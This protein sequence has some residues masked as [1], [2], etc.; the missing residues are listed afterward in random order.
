MGFDF[1]TTKIR[2][3]NGTTVAPP[4]HPAQ[5][6]HR[7]YYS[8]DG[9]SEF[10][11]RLRDAR[12]A[13][14]KDGPITLNDGALRHADKLSFAFFGLSYGISVKTR[15]WLETL[16]GHTASD[17]PY[18][19][20]LAVSKSAAATWTGGRLST[21]RTFHAIR[22]KCNEAE[23]VLECLRG[24]LDKQEMDLARRIFEHR[25][26]HSYRL[27]ETS[28]HVREA[29]GAAAAF[30]EIVRLSEREGPG[31]QTHVVTSTETKELVRQHF[32]AAFLAAGHDETVL[33]EVHDKVEIIS[34][35]DVP[36]IKPNPAGLFMVKD[37]RPL[38]FVG[39]G[40]SDAKAVQRAKAEGMRDIEFCALVTEDKV[41]EFMQYEPIA[42]ISDLGVIAEALRA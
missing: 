5:G 7:V 34:A 39:D 14:D 9:T 15:G 1:M 40:H 33:R 42:V 26:A 25:I 13:F 17:L 36:E 23:Y 4:I 35:E 20:I 31:I 41:P 12:K 24:Q 18:Q 11:R 28:K 22:T 21:E 16:K 37:S 19:D 8:Q 3:A 27:P 38:I 2:H 6:T 30:L 32:K 10:F 29:P